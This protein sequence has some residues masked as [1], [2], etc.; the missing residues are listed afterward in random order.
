MANVTLEQW[1][2][3]EAVVAHGGFAQAAAA[4]HKSQS[5]INHAV[6]KLQH[7]LGLQLL[8]VKGRKAQLTPVGETMLRR[9]RQLLAQAGQLEDAADCLSRGEEAELKLAVDVIFPP[10]CLT[11]ALKKFSDQFPLTRIQLFETV[12]SGGPEM[13]TGGEVDLLIAGDV[14]QGY[15]AEPLLQVEFVALAHPNHPLHKLG[16]TVFVDDLAQQR[17]IVVRDSGTG[18]PTDS[19]WLGAEQR[20]TVSHM[21][22]SIDMVCRGTGFAWL[23]LTRVGNAIVDGTLKELPLEQGSRRTVPLYLVSA[24][25][26]NPGPAAG[27]L[28]SLILEQVR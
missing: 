11:V 3:F 5:S 13:M 17:Q 28:S 24:S 22:S 12:L 14:P 23:P 16:R 19:G 15:L 18:A 1:R 10:E 9:A 26:D 20:W 4:V 8:E 2:M 25:Q 27:H 7:Q 6:H 21:T